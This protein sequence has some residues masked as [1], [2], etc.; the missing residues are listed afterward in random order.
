MARSVQLCW[1]HSSCLDR[2]GVYL[3][4]PGDGKPPLAQRALG[5]SKSGNS[6]LAHQERGSAEPLARFF[7]QVAPVRIPVQVSCPRG[8]RAHV[9]EATVVEFRSSHHAIFLSTLPLE[10][11]DPVRLETSAKGEFLEATVDAVQYQ[12][13]R[14]AVAVKFVN[15]PND[16]V[17]RQP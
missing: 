5:V 10:F 12:E 1:R 15:G 11:G 8:G 3:A 7:P 9:R 16:W 4:D 6:A 14:K 13:G 2:R 17:V